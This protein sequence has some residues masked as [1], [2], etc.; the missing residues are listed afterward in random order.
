LRDQAL[1]DG[2]AKVAGGAGND[3]ILAR[4]EHEIFLSLGAVFK[5]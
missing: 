2:G 4:E 1:G 5:P 3:D